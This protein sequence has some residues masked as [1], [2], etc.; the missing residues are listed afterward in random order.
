MELDGAAFQKLGDCYFFK[1]GLGTIEAR[2]SVAGRNKTKPGTPDTLFITK[3]NYIMVEYST[4]VDGL[5]NKFKDDIEKC[6]N[7]EKTGIP[8]TSINYI[9]LCYS[10]NM[11]DTD[12]QHLKALGTEK[13]ISIRF[14]GLDTLSFDLNY[15]YPCLIK[16]HLDIDIDIDTNQIL[17]LDRFLE[18]YHKNKLATPLDIKLFGRE[19]IK[20]N[21][22][23]TLNNND[24]I[25]L[26]GNAGVGKT[27]LGIACFETF[28][29]EHNDYQAYCIKNKGLPIYND[30]KSYFSKPNKYL[31]FIDD[32]DLLSRF[33]LLIDLVL[34]KTEQH[35]F[36][37]ILT[38]RD[39][40]KNK[41]IEETN[42]CNNREF[43]IEEL[44]DS[45]ICNILKNKYQI[46]NDLWTDRITQIANGN[47]KLAVM[48]ALSA[49][50]ANSVNSLRNVNDIYKQY[51][52]SILSQT[53]LGNDEK[54][55]KT[56]ASIA[57]FKHIDKTDKDK[58]SLACLLSGVDKEAFWQKAQ[59]LHRLEVV[60]IYSDIVKISDQILATYLCYLVFFQKKLIL[61]SICFD[62]KLFPNYSTQIKN[63]IFPIINHFDDTEVKGI[64]EK[65]LCP[66]WKKESSDQSSDQFK[67]LMDCFWFLKADD[68]FCY[69]DKLI[70]ELP[71]T[72]NN[73]QIFTTNNQEQLSELDILF[74]LGLFLG[75]NEYKSSL[76]LFLDYAAKQQNKASEV[77][78]KIISEY[79]FKSNSV[80]NNYDKEHILV[81]K[82]ILRLE[83]GNN[84]YFSKLFIVISSQLLKISFSEAKSGR[85]N[86]VSFIYFTPPDHPQLRKL[87]EKTLNQLIKLAK[88]SCD[89]KNLVLFQLSKN[90]CFGFNEG[91]IS[92][93][94]KADSTLLLS[95]IT[96]ELASTNLY[97]C[98]FVNRYLSFLEQQK[99]TYDRSLKTQFNSPLF[100]VLYTFVKTSDLNLKYDEIDEYQ[101]QKLNELTQKFMTKDYVDAYQQLSKS[102]KWEV[103]NCKNKLL[104]CLVNDSQINLLEF[105]TEVV[106]SGELE[107]DKFVPILIEK[108]GKKETNRIIEQLPVSQ[109]DKW[110][111]LF[112]QS[113]PQAEKTIE[114]ADKFL[115][116]I[117]ANK[118][119]YLLE[120]NTLISYEKIKP[121][122][123]VLFLRT[124]LDKYHSGL[125]PADKLGGAFPKYIELLEFC[126]GN[127]SLL[128]DIYL[129]SEKFSHNDHDGTIF[130]SLIDNDSSFI[131]SYVQSH[132]NENGFFQKD[133]DRIWG[134]LWLRDDYLT[135]IKKL[136]DYFFQYEKP[137]AIYSPIEHLFISYPEAYGDKEVIKRQFLFLEN[138]IRNNSAN[139]KL[140]K[141]LFSV[142]IRF[143]SNKFYF[144]RK[145]LDSNDNIDDFKKLPLTPSHCSW[146]GSRAPLLEKE[147]VFLKEIKSYCT[148]KNMFTH[149]QYLQ[150]LI[151]CKT[152]HIENE[153]KKDFTDDYL[154][155]KHH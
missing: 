2:G 86:T 123:I 97:H 119:F 33:N 89:Y 77:L 154:P 11:T 10:A 92:S 131:E 107:P 94:A 122:F 134:F 53:K 69:Y 42:K 132:F 128:S 17:S 73:D 125:M 102:D 150:E 98:I 91:E 60:D 44:N 15:N 118:S 78:S 82:L 30:L 115:K 27:R 47:P 137:P 63:M 136:I 70:K 148:E 3:D 90:Y 24:V 26:S 68:I 121:D 113:I 151:K 4:Q 22:L 143:G 101:R 34:E 56:A 43:T 155:K 64:I 36:K 8:V 9:I 62:C 117:K 20:K 105:I 114:D 72:L 116:L 84:I 140:I 48:L 35:D 5:G 74:R 51:F 142:I 120:I 18:I 25:V 130:S 12:R 138:E 108:S 52:S 110:F 153:L 58:L 145:F 149:C 100:E 40:A 67:I 59:D 141:G 46:T 85:N 104:D 147:S 49:K 109:S 135:L 14:V 93:L 37:I 146:S 66:I 112:F 103:I 41:V 28:L 88:N 126:K 129:I 29:N 96:Q 13:N 21:I 133:Y 144:Y 54:L 55:I 76:T 45:D 81:D 39:Y 111:F 1:K 83:D 79:C 75:I 95:F 7:Q 65:A 57:F 19:D 38:V 6:L 106:K 139:T 23:D 87:R 31:I 32:V 80:Y 71:T 50:K 16:E 99:I 152:K 127:E 124:I 61:F